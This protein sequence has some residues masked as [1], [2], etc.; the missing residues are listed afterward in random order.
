MHGNSQET[1]EADGW[2]GASRSRLDLAG[3]SPAETH[4]STVATQLTLFAKIPNV[5]TGRGR[6]LARRS[7][8]YDDHR[9]LRED[10]KHVVARETG[11]QQVY[12]VPTYL[13]AQ[14]AAVPG[15]YGLMSALTFKPVE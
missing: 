15:E 1:E 4:S 3:N 2:L 12:L 13:P 7:C 6:L 10:V 8:R 5:E 9:N 14:H 11:R